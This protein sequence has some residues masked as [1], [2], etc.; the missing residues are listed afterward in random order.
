MFDF[1]KLIDNHIA[2]E[3]RPKEIGRYYP[4]EIGNCLRKVWYTYK[5]PKEIEPD[6]LKIFELGNILH[7]FVV[8]VLKSE[9]NKEVKLLKSEFPIKIDM[10]DFVVSGRVDDL[11]LVRESGRD[12]LVEVKSTKDVD[13]IKKPQISHV[14]QL[15]LYMYATDIHNG[16]ILYIDKNNLRSKIFEI[17]F[18]RVKSLKIVGRFNTLHRHLIENVLPFAEA[19]HT[20]DMTWMCRFCEYRKK[21]DRNEP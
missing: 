4:S 18:D 7:G 9:K 1:N 14:M 12:V 13:G 11:I 10:K 2:R 3:H 15:M 20:N 17:P 5:Y 8:E 6:L 16:I 19:K 21:C